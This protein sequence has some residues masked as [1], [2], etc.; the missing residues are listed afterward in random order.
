MVIQGANDPRVPQIEADQI[1]EKVKSK[2]GVCEYLLFTDEGHG[3]A[4]IPNQ[5]KA[6]TAAADFLD[7]FVKN[8]PTAEVTG[9][10]TG[11]K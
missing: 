7:K 10:P 11:D 5:I 4:K 8:R 1:A 2:G 3:L 9:S 6:Y